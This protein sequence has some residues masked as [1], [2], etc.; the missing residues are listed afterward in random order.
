MPLYRAIGQMCG[1]ELPAALKERVLK[2]QAAANLRLEVDAFHRG[3]GAKNVWNCEGRRRRLAAFIDPEKHHSPSAKEIAA[4]LAVLLAGKPGGVVGRK[5]V[6]V[7]R[8]VLSGT[9]GK[10]LG[11]EG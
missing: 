10:P 1:E 7:D 9:L 11:L 5:I 4:L 6:D 2:T 8:A 3:M